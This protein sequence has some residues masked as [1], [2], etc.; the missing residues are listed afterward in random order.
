LRAGGPPI[1]YNPAI[2]V[3]RE[4]DPGELELIGH[5]PLVQWRDWFRPTG[6]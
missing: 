1:R 4:I 5:E 3:L 6:R 2:Q